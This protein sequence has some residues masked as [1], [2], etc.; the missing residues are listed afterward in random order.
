MSDTET[1]IIDV[2]PWAEPSAEQMDMFDSLSP[3]E[4]RKMIDEAIEEG[5]EGG[6]SDRSMREVIDE[7][8]AERKS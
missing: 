3:E 2:Y 5:F 1:I 7:A 6:L 4:Q 8:K